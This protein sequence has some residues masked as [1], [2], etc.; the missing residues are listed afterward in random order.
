M[1]KNTF[2]QGIALAL[3]A[4]IIW[5]GNFIIAK[6]L[7]HQIPPISLAYFRWLTACALLVP[8]A[9]QNMKADWSKVKKQ[10]LL[11]L[12]TALTGITLFNTFVYVAGNTTTAINMALIGTTSSPVFAT[13]LAAI[14]LKET[15]TLQ[16]IFGMI[17]CITG[18]ILL[19]SKGKVHS[20]LKFNFQTGDWWILLAGF[21]FAIYNVLV[22]KKSVYFSALGFLGWIFVI[23]TILLT[24]AFLVELNYWGLPPF[25]TSTI[26]SILYLG[27]GTSVISFLCWNAAINRMGTAT[28][29]L[30]GNLIPLFAAAEAV[31]LLNE[32]FGMLHLWSAVLLISGLIIANL[33]NR[34]L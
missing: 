16:R 15:I 23:G 13:I 22:R 4:V 6:A 20:L 5:S 27:L 21:T 34:R 18:I 31:L 8:F 30:F 26:G 32:A 29:A 33:Q 12:F 28:T 9:W 25:Q 7:A 2:Y 19:L 24:P 10:W 3:I 1:I 17:L 11:L 14:F